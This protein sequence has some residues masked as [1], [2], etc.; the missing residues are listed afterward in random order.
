MAAAAVGIITAFFGRL[1][2][3]ASDRAADELAGRVLAVVEGLRRGDA[4]AGGAI[5]QLRGYPGDRTAAAH[6]RARIAQAAADPGFRA[7][8]DAALRSAAPTAVTGHHN[9]VLTNT[10]S[11]R[12]RA[13]IDN[14]VR[15][16]TRISGWPWL[17]GGATVVVAAV[18]LLCAAG[19][20]TVV[21]D[22]TTLFDTKTTLES[23][24]GWRYK[25]SE[26]RLRT[27]PQLD[28]TGPA[29][30]GYKYLYFDITVENLLD[31]REAPGVDF[32]F[33]RPE[34]SLGPDCGAEQTPFFGPMSSYAAG[35]VPGWCLSR[36]GSLFGAGTSCYETNDDFLRHVDRI[37]PGGR[38]HVRCLDSYLVAD[39]FDLDSIR[40]YYL[41]E[42][43]VSRGDDLP[44]L[45][46]VP[47]KT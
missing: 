2:T 28:D 33:A 1:A 34:S 43:V 39:G 12:L 27:S 21:H 44:F 26:A 37:P 40:V 35:I 6:L 30:P 29:R 7:A 19:G 14:S 45:R 38:N 4:V 16:I 15:N 20:Y 3:R 23:S 25:V 17:V 10:G 8:L 32:H 31:D 41:G 5:A 24:G 36:A 22:H 13:T 46:Q 18:L 11:G 9:A 42:S 47:T